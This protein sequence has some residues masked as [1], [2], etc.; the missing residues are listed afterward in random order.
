MKIPVELPNR[1][2][3]HYEK[4]LRE[5][6]LIS[7]QNHD[8]FIREEST[9]A[10]HGLSRSAVR[11]ILQQIA[12]QSLLRHVPRRGWR[13]RPFSQ[14]D[15][16]DYSQTRAVL[17]L[18][19]LDLAKGKLLDVDLQAMLDGNILPKTDLDAPIINNQ[20][21]DYIIK[22]SGSFY[23]QDFFERHASFFRILFEWEG[24]DRQAA[25]Q[26]IEQHHQ[27]LR[28][29]L[30]RN[31]DEA[32]KALDYHIYNNHPVLTADHHEKLVQVLS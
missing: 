26:A 2:Q 20:L 27:I 8:V 30:N 9:A 22:K 18:K 28:A 5:I 32:A 31:W 7:L 19:A 16:R 25:I 12:G 15:L 17:E 13:I 23:I 14:D 11:S 3:G 10:R 1:Q 4:I 29:L 24:E 21:H 6:V